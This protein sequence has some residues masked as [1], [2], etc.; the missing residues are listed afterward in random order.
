MVHKVCE[1]PIR[2]GAMIEAGAKERAFTRW[3]LRHRTRVLLRPHGSGGR[4]MKRQHI[5]GI[6]SFRGP[7]GFVLKPARAQAAQA[8]Y[9]GGRSAE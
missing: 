5:T 9:E 1:V 3:F 2:G 7:R 6:W 8:M 4:R